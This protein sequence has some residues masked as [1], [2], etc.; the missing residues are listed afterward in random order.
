MAVHF[1]NN[2]ILAKI[3][4]VKVFLIVIIVFKNDAVF[5]KKLFVRYVPFV[6]EKALFDIYI[7]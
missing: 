7:L 3:I 4:I 5:L 2:I 1:I 6:T